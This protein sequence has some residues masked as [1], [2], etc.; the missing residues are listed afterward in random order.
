MFFVCDMFNTFLRPRYI[1]VITDN[2]KIK[3]SKLVLGATV[4][5]W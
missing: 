5:E 4:A 2:N 3:G 1:A